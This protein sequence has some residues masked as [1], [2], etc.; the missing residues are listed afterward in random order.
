[1]TIRMY[2]KRKNIALE[3][4]SVELSHTR[5]HASDCEVREASTPVIDVLQREVKLVGDLSV[6]EREKLLLIADKC[7]VHKTL[8]GDIDIKTVEVS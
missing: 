3:S 5:E 7:S 2:A 4:V 6:E 1:M 8:H